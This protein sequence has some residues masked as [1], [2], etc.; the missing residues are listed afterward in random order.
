M[1]GTC[2]PDSVTIDHWVMSCRAFSRRIE[3]RC[4]AWVFDHFEAGEVVL[5][6]ISTPRNGPMQEFLATFLGTAPWQSLHIP[7]ALFQERCPA[8]HHSLLETA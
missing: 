1:V 4:M 7:R 2:Y 5:R 8:L 3:H 6:F